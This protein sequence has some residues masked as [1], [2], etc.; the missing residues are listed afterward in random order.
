M[1]VSYADSDEQLMLDITS[2]LRREG[3]Q[4]VSRNSA[5]NTTSYGEGGGAPLNVCGV[6]ILTNGPVEIIKKYGPG[7]SGMC[8]AILKADVVIVIATRNYFESYRCRLEAFY[9]IHP[10]CHTVPVLFDRQPQDEA[11]SQW[12]GLNQDWMKALKLKASK[13]VNGNKAT[14]VRTA[15]TVVKG[16]LYTCGISTDEGT[17]KKQT[18]MKK[19]NEGG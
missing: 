19:K 2:G 8:R 11:A 4:I 7:V 1:Y 16:I 13:L 12:D 3:I 10:S 5:A 9:L 17:Q 18:S 15:V 14:S 6:D